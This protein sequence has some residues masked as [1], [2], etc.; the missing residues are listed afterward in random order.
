[1]SAIIIVKPKSG[2]S[3][4]IYHGP[5]ADGEHATGWASAHLRGYDW[6]CQDLWRP[7]ST[8]LTCNVTDVV[9]FVEGVMGRSGTDECYV[10]IDG[11]NWCVTP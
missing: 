6:H 10:T 1:M 5:F 7:G 4:P 8:Y 2:S 9:D 11:A 3:E